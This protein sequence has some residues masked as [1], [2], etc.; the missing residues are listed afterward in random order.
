MLV[1]MWYDMTLHVIQHDVIWYGVAYLLWR[2]MIRLDVI[3]DAPCDTLSFDDMIYCHSMLWFDVSNSMPWLLD[4]DTSM[5]Y[6]HG[7]FL[8]V[9]CC[10]SKSTSHWAPYCCKSI[11]ALNWSRMT[12]HPVALFRTHISHFMIAC[13]LSFVIMC[14]LMWLLRRS[15]SRT[16]LRAYVRCRWG[17]GYTWYLDVMCRHTEIRMPVEM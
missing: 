3:F 14:H 7:S 2:T 17:W 9:R 10:W 13:L 12:C 5:L 8:K 4:N 16:C 15:A 11:M 6:I 1:M